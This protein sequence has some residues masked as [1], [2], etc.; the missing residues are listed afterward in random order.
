MPS[1][2][3]PIL[4][5]V[6]AVALIGGGGAV[7]HFLGSRNT[8]KPPAPAPSDPLAALGRAAREY[9]ADIVKA[10]A[11]ALIAAADKIRAGASVADAQKE[12]DA[13]FKAERT[14][15]FDAKVKVAM[16]A[17][18]PPDSDLKDPAK[19][20][21]HVGAL[22]TIAH[23]LDPGLPPMPPRGPPGDDEPER[24][25]RAFFGWSPDHPAP[26][27]SL[28]FPPLTA[29][30]PALVSD[31][32]PD[33]VFLFRAY[34][35]VLGSYPAYI[36]Q[37]IGDCTSFGTGHALDTEQVV[38]IG[39]IGGDKSQYREISTEAL[40]GVGRELAGMLG[41][42][43]GCYGAPLAKAAVEVGTVS[44]EDVGP[45]S[46]KRAKEWGR[47]GVPADIK[48][49]AADHKAAGAAKVTSIKEA[50]AALASG[51]PVVV[52]SNVGFEGTR[53]GRGVIRANGHWP[54]CMHVNAYRPGA[55]AGT[56]EFL[57]CQSW[58]PEMPTGP[59]SDG[60]PPNSFWIVEADMGRILAADDS[61]AIS[62]YGP[63]VK[64]TLPDR[65]TNSGY[66]RPAD[67]GG[68]TPPPPTP[69]TK[70]RPKKAA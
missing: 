23:A 33:S 36:A 25:P 50:R 40:Y 54:H 34:T 43:D 3:G 12:D 63:F 17:I 4:A 39:L 47:K 45:Y 56:T 6:A 64:R 68:V 69:D 10:K 66:A 29:A 53:D 48:A 19:R 52:C 42:G 9:A 60:Q 14:K 38:Q 27:A 65:W 58:G 5:A 46:G 8:P 26:P 30:A 44:R 2:R 51:Y 18:T 15:A 1:N 31:A 28:T 32:E 70:P 24:N 67:P 20:A 55:K 21:A 11:R 16:D 35:D 37:Q 62:G 41:N 22:Y 59:L 49:K 7:G 57:V 61:H 13:V